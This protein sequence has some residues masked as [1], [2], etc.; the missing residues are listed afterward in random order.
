MLIYHETHSYLKIQ[1]FKDVTSHQLVD[2]YWSF[3]GA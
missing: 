3:R 1:D 2:S